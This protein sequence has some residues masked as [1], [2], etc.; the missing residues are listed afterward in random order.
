[1]YLTAFP[2]LILFTINWKIQLGVC[3]PILL[4]S[5]ILVIN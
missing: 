2:S 1:M 5:N 4:V 3:I